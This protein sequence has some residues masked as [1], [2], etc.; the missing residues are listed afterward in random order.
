M[1]Q[2]MFWILVKIRVKDS[3]LKLYLKFL[4]VQTP[5]PKPQTKFSNKTNIVQEP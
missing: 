3:T 5:N 1:E 2:K 4:S